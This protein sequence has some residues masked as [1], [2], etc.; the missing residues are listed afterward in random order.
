MAGG[1]G[2]LVLP[3]LEVGAHEVRIDALALDAR[4]VV[5]F[6]GQRNRLVRV[7]LEGQVDVAPVEDQGAVDGAGSGEA[8]A[9]PPRPMADQPGARHG[10]PTAA[11]HR[12]RQVDGQIGA[13]LGGHAQA[14]RG[15]ELAHARLHLGFQRRIGLQPLKRL[16]MFVGDHEH[17]GATA[18]NPRQFGRVQQPFHGAVHHESRRRQPLDHRFPALDHVRCAGR[19]NR[20]RCG[21]RR[22]GNHQVKGLG[23]Q[24]QQRELRQ[25]SIDAAGLG[26][27]ENGDLLPRLHLA[28]AEDPGEAIDPLALDPS[29]QHEPP[30]FECGAV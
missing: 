23:A 3:S 6:N 26:L 30:P 16:R 20:H 24:A 19:A 1:V 13:R 4:D 2:V 11:H 29:L 18:Q 9:K 17:T 12:A 7:A 8:Q 25:L 10:A 27:R 22:R 21:L 14:L 28:T 5:V 15:A